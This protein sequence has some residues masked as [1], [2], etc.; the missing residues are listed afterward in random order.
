[1]RN[2][3]APETPVQNLEPN[4]K[5]PERRKEFCTS[6]LWPRVGSACAPLASGLLAG[7]CLATAQWGT[8]W[9]LKREQRPKRVEQLRE[10][11]YRGWFGYFKEGH[12]GM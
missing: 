9:F 4:E 12:G 1:M 3:W 7:L 10:E 6:S 2:E 5:L 11:L 8:R